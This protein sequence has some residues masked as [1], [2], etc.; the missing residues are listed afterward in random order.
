MAKRVLLCASAFH[1]SAA[2]WNGSRLT[3]CR[4]F[5]D[6]P[7][8]H[9]AFQQFVLT[10]AG[11]P[12]YLTADTVDED[13]RFETLP[14]ASG[15]DRREMLERKL[16][17]LYRSTP[18]YGAVLQ[19]REKDKRRDDRY[20]LSAL[21][22]A[23]VFA[24]WLQILL[25]AKAP[26]AGV[27]PLPLVTLGALKKLGLAEPNLLVVSRHE[28]GVRQTFVKDQV[29]R[30]SRLTPTPVGGQAPDEAYA[31]EIR[32]TRMYLDALNITHVEDLVTVAILDQ[33]GT[34]SA[35]GP[36][37]VAGRRNVRWVRIAADD[38]VSKLG[39]DRAAL[40]QTA[41][42]LP[43]HLLGLHAPG[44]NLAPPTLTAGYTRYRASRAVYAGAGVLAVLAAAWAGFN[45]SQLMDLARERDRLQAEAQRQ[46]AVYQDI[47]RTFPPTP[48]DSHRLRMTVDAAK[49]LADMARLPDKAYLA[50]SRGLDAN[51]DITLTGLT[52][53]H[54][55][56]AGTEPPQL[57]QTAV[58]QVELLA[59]PGD[60]ATALNIVNKLVKD[61]GRQELVASAR[62][63]RQPVNLASGA[64]MRGSTTDA[65]KAQ[66]VPVQFD[67]ELVL[68]PGV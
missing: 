29:F 28:A 60:I 40:Q 21:T 20:L 39:L 24:P 12:V 64:T 65:R 31:E 48:A 13:Y 47:T 55:R 51:P 43:L 1:L 30:V 35:L 61:L 6:D 15:S 18:F 38:L 16:R 10:V 33:D 22:N 5:E 23:D 52:W 54:A 41:D 11:I 56:V 26:V 32:N 3:V 50:V 2:V 45:V 27:F 7:E 59:P 53:R 34:L 36:R 57:A 66:P 44:L 62:T 25:T 49:R 42:A 58:M 9:N 67:V 4:S 46:Q 68:K 17:Q 8:G 14:H 37:I 63:T 19:D